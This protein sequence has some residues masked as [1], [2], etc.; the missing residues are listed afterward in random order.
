MAIGLQL[1]GIVSVIVGA[2]LIA[3]A[4]GFIAAGVLLATLGVALER[5]KSA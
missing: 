3:P 4:V 5:N 2:F 1:C